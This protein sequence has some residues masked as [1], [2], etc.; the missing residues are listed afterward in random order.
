M[1]LV[2]GELLGRLGLETDNFDQG[3]DRA[4]GGFKK[5]GTKLTGLA[6]VVGGGVATAL[7]SALMDAMSQQD[8]GAKI[9]AQLGHSSKYAA[10]YGRIAGE[11]YA[12]GWGESVQAVGDTIAAIARQRLV[13]EDAGADAIAR[14]ATQAQ[15]L[16]DVLGQDVTKSTL[17]AQNL[18]RNGLAKD[19]TEAFDLIARGVQEGVDGSEDLL[20][21]FKEYSTQF[22]DLGLNG[23]QALG[24]LSQGLKA[25]ARDSDTIADALKEF[26]I[27][28]QDAS[29]TSAAAFKALGI[30]ASKATADIASGGPRAAAA[31]DLVLDRLRATKDPVARNAAAVGLFGTKAEDLQD[32][33]FALDASTAAGQIGNVAGAVDKL[34]D[35][36]SQTASAKLTAFKRGVQQS[37]VEEMAKALPAVEAVFGFLAEHKDVVM[38]I[39]AGLGILAGLILAIAAAVKV[40]TV[41]QIA[42]NI[43]MSLNP[44]GLIIIAIVALVAGI[45]LLWNNSEAF[46]NFFIGAWDMIW[47]AVK[48]VWN[49]VKE[50]W[51]LL[52][53]I[54]TG[55]IGLAVLWITKHWD[56]IKAGASA[57]W[58]WIV[59][60]FNALV[61]FITS[62]PGRIAK[63]AKNMWNGLVDAFKGAIN[64]IIGL[65]NKLDLSLQIGPFPSWVPEIGGKTFGIP[66]L[67]PDLPM[68][69]RGGVIEPRN[70]GTAAIM[71]EAGQREIAAPEPLLRRLLAEY[72]GRDTTVRL[73][74]EGTGLLRGIRR[75]ARVG[76]GD[77]DV[78]LVGA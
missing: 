46:R 19:A 69:A 61:D 33:L 2:V 71:G 18:I 66:D 78:V 8:V 51:P 49:W 32:A 34:G 72:A 6:G 15:I 57:V 55:P 17:A 73:L 20:D 45:V 24:L 76:G 75:E 28:G 11:L 31:L 27:R 37:L 25:G 38:P 48:F 14:V 13:P 42:L 3:L 12:Q 21:T 50:N 62:L 47:G 4:E 67:F 64:W 70:G 68:L 23:Q 63:G 56:D 65:W 60:R 7:G 26:A 40:W 74:I 41:A 36:V 58:K 29:S 10:E 39:I 44:I 54:L 77:A 35:T 1:A 9:A 30:D 52:L 5:F 59:G 53:A 43:A 16:A 22:R